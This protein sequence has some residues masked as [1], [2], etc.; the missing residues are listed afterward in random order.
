MLGEPPLEET[1]FGLTAAAVDGGAK[2]GGGLL[3][4]S[5]LGQQLAADGEQQV[6]VLQFRIAFERLNRLERGGRS[7]HFGDRDG[8][9]Q[10]DDR[11]LVQRDELIVQL[12]NGRPV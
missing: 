9:I 1:P 5:E 11:R 3:V 8:A 4:P 2:A 12:E 10:R 7:T 6:I